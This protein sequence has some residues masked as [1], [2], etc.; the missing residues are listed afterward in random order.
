VSRIIFNVT[1]FNR[2][3]AFKIQE[4]NN[5][6]QSKTI[7]KNHQKFALFLA[8]AFKLKVGRLMGAFEVPFSMQKPAN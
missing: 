7:L 4:K 3:S 1:I 6:C 2:K 8:K 5:S